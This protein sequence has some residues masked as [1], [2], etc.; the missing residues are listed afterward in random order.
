MPGTEQRLAGA[1]QMQRLVQATQ[2][3]D[4]L[5]F[6]FSGHGSQVPDYSGDETDG[7]NETLCPCDF[8][9]VCLPQHD[10]LLQPC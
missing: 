4:S 3:G 7:L 5:L 10:A 8:R 6:Q 2:P 9:S 1:V